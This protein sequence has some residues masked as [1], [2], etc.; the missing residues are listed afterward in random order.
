MFLK[1]IRISNENLQYSIGVRFVIQMLFHT[2]QIKITKLFML[3]LLTCFCDIKKVPALSSRDLTANQ[4][5]GVNQQ[6]T[7]FYDD[8]FHRFRLCCCIQL[9]VVH[10]V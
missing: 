3:K 1:F 6:K 4:I 10:T 9:I 2:T 8:H 5:I 7:L